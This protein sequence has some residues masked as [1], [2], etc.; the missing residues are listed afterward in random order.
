MPSNT[1]GR[2]ILDGSDGDDWIVDAYFGE[3]SVML[4]GTGNDVFD[5]FLQG[6]IDGGEGRDELR[7]SLGARPD[8]IDFHAMRG[9]RR[10]D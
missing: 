4:G 7:L 2:D 5:A 8:A 6:E 10:P 9:R 3:G 1:G